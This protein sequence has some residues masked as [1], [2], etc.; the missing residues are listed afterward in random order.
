MKMKSYLRNFTAFNPG[1]YEE[2]GIVVSLPED[3]PNEKIEN[4]KQITER[5]ASLVSQHETL[6]DKCRRRYRKNGKIELHADD[7]AMSQEAFVSDIQIKHLPIVH[8]ATKT[9]VTDIDL[10]VIIEQ[11]FG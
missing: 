6:T 3:S 4:N 2:M 9:P 11:V 1:V 7:F 5:R 10:G 8:I